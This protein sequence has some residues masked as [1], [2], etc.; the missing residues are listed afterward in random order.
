MNDRRI[1]R[2]LCNSI[3]TIHWRSTI[4][5]G[6]SSE[7]QRRAGQACVRTVSAE[8]E[9]HSCGHPGDRGR[10]EAVRNRAG[11]DRF[12]SAEQVEPSQPGCDEAVPNQPQGAGSHLSRSAVTTK[13]RL[14]F[15]PYRGDYCCHSYLSAVIGLTLVARRAGR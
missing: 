13:H 4:S 12:G 9:E 3:P 1:Q 10:K 2:A 6:L 7:K 14:C 5:D 8:L 11:C 15:R